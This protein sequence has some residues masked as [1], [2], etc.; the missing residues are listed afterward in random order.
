MRY[1]NISE[2]FGVTGKINIS[3]KEDSETIMESLLHAEELAL[4]PT[5]WSE[6]RKKTF[7]MGRLAAKQAMESYGTTTY[8]VLRGSMNEPLWPD[9]FKGS[10]A[11]KDNIAIAAVTKDPSYAGI[12]I[13]IEDAHSF[14]DTTHARLFCVDEE[15]TY[16]EENSFNATLFFSIKESVVKANYMAY[17][18][19]TEMI[20]VNCCKL[21]ENR[22]CPK[23]KVKYILENRYIISLCMIYQEKNKNNE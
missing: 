7:V 5:T 17:G 1:G 18:K 21:L 8:P 19:R 3:V 10:I 16:V 2:Q 9:T 6:K 15:L 4:I 14:L 11:H 23:V 20:N 22:S 12:G 13:D